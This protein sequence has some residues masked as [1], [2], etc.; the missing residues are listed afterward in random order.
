[1]HCCLQEQNAL[2]R[3]AGAAMPNFSDDRP[4]VSLPALVA[5]ER[6]AH[7]LNFARAAA[8][9]DVTATAI[10]KTIKTLELQLNVRL[11]NR[12][13]RSVGLT[14][15][16]SRLLSTLAPA[17]DIIKSSVREIGETAARPTGVLRIN[18]SHVAFASV[19]Q[20]F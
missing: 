17:L 13:T 20:P 15:H 3:T 14:E 7:H 10:S 19:I 11:F 9:L 8:E 12:T 18:T 2:R 1:M 6:V 4:Q 5:F 16:G